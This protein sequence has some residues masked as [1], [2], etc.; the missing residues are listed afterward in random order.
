MKLT[1]VTKPD[2]LSEVVDRQRLKIDFVVSSGTAK[3]SRLKF[4]ILGSLVR[5]QPG[6]CCFSRAQT[7]AVRTAQLAP[8]QSV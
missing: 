6:A 8:W 4:L 2:M 1:T 5:V 7:V 3:S